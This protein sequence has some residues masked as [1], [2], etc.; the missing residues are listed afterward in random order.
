M[1][2]QFNTDHHIT[3]GEKLT[4]SLS[5]L[6]TEGLNRFSDHITRPEVHLTD[7]NESRTWLD[8][9]KCLLEVR[10]EGR[11]PIAVSAHANNYELAVD[12]AIDKIKSS[13]DSVF[14]RLKDHSH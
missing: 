13:L 5:D 4:T 10:A 11:R 9:K 14:D 3:A 6:I 1:Q 7:G 8:D 12:A 2:I